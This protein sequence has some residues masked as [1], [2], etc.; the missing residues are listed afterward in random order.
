MSGDLPSLESVFAQA[1]E[2]ASAEERAAFLDQVCRSDPEL[3]REV[4]KLVTD[5]FRAGG[6]LEKPAVPGLATVD[7]APV[8]E[9]PGTVIGPYKLMEQIGEGGMGLVFVAEQQHP[10]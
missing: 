4:Q 8:V 5:Y 10:V 2:L 7:E 6:F 9:R 3:R 1:I